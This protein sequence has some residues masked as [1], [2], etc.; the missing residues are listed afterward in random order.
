MTTLAF[1]RTFGEVFAAPAADI[2]ATLSVHPAGIDTPPHAH[3]NDY[4]CVVLAG[5]FRESSSRGDFD[6]GP[7]DAVVHRDGER[8]RDSFGPHGARCL[9]LHVPEGLKAEPGGRRCDPRVRSLA[10]ELAAEVAVGAPDGL[11]LEALTAELFGRL[12]RDPEDGGEA[13]WLAGVI[14][15][16]DAEPHL[17]WRLEDVAALAGRHPSHLA[18]TFRRRTGVSLGAWRRRRRLTELA[19]RLRRGNEPLADLAADLGYADQAHMTREFRTR[20]CAAPAAWRREL[21]Q[22]GPGMTAD[23]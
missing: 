5:A 20:A 14:E 6:W 1:G 7:G 9:N 10:E 11:A 22:A 3:A 8:H 21:V 16:I 17:A 15:A 4:V 18:R 2:T 13:G 23:A 19:L 12:A